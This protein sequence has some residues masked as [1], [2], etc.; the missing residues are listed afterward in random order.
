MKYIMAGDRKVVQFDDRFDYEILDETF[1]PLYIKKRGNIKRW[2]EE[3]AVDSARANSRAVKARQ[4][5]SKTAS[6]Y[7]TAM[8]MDAATITDDF[9]VKDETDK[10]TWQEI[11]FRRNDFFGLSLYRDFEGLSLKPSRTPELT[12][13]GAR[14][15]GWRLEDGCWWLYKNEPEEEMLSE[16]LTYRI[17]KMFG[18]PMAE[19]ELVEQ[20]E[21]GRFIRTRDF[22]EGRYNLQ[23]M[24]SLVVDHTEDGQEVPD[25]DYQYNYNTL[26]AIR[27]ELAQ[28]YLQICILD[29]LCEN[30]DRHTKNYGL[31]TERKTGKIVS[32]APNYDNNNSLFANYGLKKDRNGGL[33]KEFLRFVNRACIS[34]TVPEFV[35]SKLRDVLED[36]QMQVKE[37]FDLAFLTEFLCNGVQALKDP[38]RFLKQTRSSMQRSR[39]R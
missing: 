19:Y 35:E 25:D 30:Y 28:Q 17:G 4:R 2:I 18:Y 32:L 23:H 37:P 5:L 12:N 7:E 38:E 1:A 9:W 24:D 14:E 15:K 10:R 29:A 26:Y 13:I 27:P 20:V 33:L 31:L 16:Y 22:T 3:R 34:L 21:Q 39:N 11:E 8:K 36:V 6:D